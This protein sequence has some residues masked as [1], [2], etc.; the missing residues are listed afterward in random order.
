MVEGPVVL[1]VSRVVV[2]TQSIQGSGSDSGK[3]SGAGSTRLPVE[4]HKTRCRR[5]DPESIFS[6]Q[7]ASRE[8]GTGNG[9]DGRGPEEWKYYY[10]EV[11]LLGREPPCSR[12]LL[13]KRQVPEL[14]LPQ[15]VRLQL[16]KTLP[17]V[18]RTDSPPDPW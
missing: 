2:D 16:E 6:V 4:T 5:E 14:P 7:V 18:C 15:V 1:E 12:Q 11:P 3:F 17:L 13:L 9:S 10:Q 8:T